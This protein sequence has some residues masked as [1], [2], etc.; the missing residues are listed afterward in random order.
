M[1]RSLT[2]DLSGKVT[3]FC[4]TAYAGTDRIPKESF[5]QGSKRDELRPDREQQAHRNQNLHVGP[6]IQ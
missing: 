4:H 1:I 6:D 5:M 3:M 2:W